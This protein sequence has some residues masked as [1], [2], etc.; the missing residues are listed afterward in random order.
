MVNLNHFQDT[1]LL[2][3]M[4]CARLQEARHTGVTVHVTTTIH[5]SGATRDNKTTRTNE[6][7]EG[8]GRKKETPKPNIA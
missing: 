3:L 1:A 4:V 5:S 7:K 8:R 6:R 2:A